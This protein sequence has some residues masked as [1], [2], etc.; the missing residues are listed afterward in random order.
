[1]I[2]HRPLFGVVAAVGAFG[3]AEFRAS[4]MERFVPSV[5]AERLDRREA[6]SRYDVDAIPSGSRP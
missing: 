6:A 4:K 5:A 2:A 3:L 1:L